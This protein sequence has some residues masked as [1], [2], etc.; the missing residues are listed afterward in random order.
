[1]P[2][3]EYVCE[4]CKENFERLVMRSGEKAECPKCGSRRNTMQFSVFAAPANG[5][6]KSAAKTATPSSSCGCTPRGCG[7]H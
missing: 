5:D 6:E 3:Y 1:M 4:E 2:I 7:C